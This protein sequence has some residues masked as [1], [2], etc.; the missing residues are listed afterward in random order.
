M[1]IVEFETQSESET[2]SEPEPESGSEAQLR[3]Q[4]ER[5]RPKT[6][7]KPSQQVE[8]YY[9]APLAPLTKKRHHKTPAEWT[10]LHGSRGISRTRRLSDKAKENQQQKTEKSFKKRLFDKP[11]PIPEEGDIFSVEEVEFIPTDS[12]K[13]IEYFC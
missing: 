3:L 7:E 11:V 12:Y 2:E 1:S 8:Q 13:A 10:E 4:L 6:P 9:T 5:E